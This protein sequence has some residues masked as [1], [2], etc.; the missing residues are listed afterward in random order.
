MDRCLR[1]YADLEQELRTHLATLDRLSMPIPAQPASASQA[2]SRRLVLSS[3]QPETRGQKMFQGLSGKAAVLLAALGLMSVG[4]LGAAAAGGVNGH[5]PVNDV[6]SSIGVV[7]RASSTATDED[8]D[9]DVKNHGSDVSQKVH[10]AI[11]STTPGPGRGIAVSQAAC[12]AAH[13][14][15]TL[16]TPAQNAP[17]QK[18]RTPKP[19]LCV[20]PNA[21]GTPG[22]G[23]DSTE[24]AVTGTPEPSSTSTA[25]Q[26]STGQPQSPGKSGEEHGKPDFAPNNGN[27]ASGT[28]SAGPGQSSTAPGRSNQPPN[29]GGPPQ[30]APGRPA[31]LPNGG[32]N[33]PNGGSSNGPNGGGSSSNNPGRGNGR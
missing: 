5:G 30:S 14:R 9:A 16:P 21:D 2:Q 26:Q 23:H 19:E 18:D 29:V 7:E 1:E 25:S 3:L 31:N 15:T 28:P 8:E 27:S 22:R 33:G 13:D 12:E 17:G 6:L 11:A 20:H 10:D 24:P 4:T 32:S